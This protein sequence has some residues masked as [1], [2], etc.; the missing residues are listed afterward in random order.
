MFI[1]HIGAGLALK[2]FDPDINAGWL[3]GSALL[4]D[5]LLWIFVFA[6]VENVLV[7]PD[8]NTRHYLFFEF[9][10]THS[11]VAAFLWSIVCFG[12]T[13]GVTR[14]KLASWIILAAVFSHFILDVLVHPS[15]IPTLGSQ[16]PKLGLG[17]WDMLYLELTI[18]VLLLSSGFWVFLKSSSIRR[19]N[20]YILGIVLVLVTAITVVGQLMG[21]AP[22]S[23][24]Q[25]AFSSLSLI[26]LLVLLFFFMDKKQP[27]I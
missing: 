26:I 4:L 12:L 20:Q 22:E 27:T 6:G 24:F 13:K 14:R 1:G 15:Q 16:S 9:P 10:F 17:L 5:I 7:P 18:E 2:K 3:V 8:Y 19:R 21:P 23:S 25:V 11:L